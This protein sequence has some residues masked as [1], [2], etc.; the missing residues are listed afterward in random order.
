MS[1]YNI[2]HISVFSFV[3]DVVVQ[4]T[5]TTMAD[6]RVTPFYDTSYIGLLKRREGG[7]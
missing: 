6:G 5:R 7:T 4:A 2:F 1:L 3:A